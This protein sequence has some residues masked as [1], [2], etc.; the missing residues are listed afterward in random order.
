VQQVLSEIGAA[1]IPQLLVLNKMD[2]LP[3]GAAEAE[4]LGRRLLGESDE[5]AAIRAIAISGLSGEGVDRLLAAIDEAL[6]L[7]PIVTATFHLSA[8][9][10]A[11]LA[12]LH[13]LGR[14]LEVKYD[15]ESCEVRAEVP[16]SVK[17]RLEK[18][19]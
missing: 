18:K 12:M 1:E 9:D 11:T 8:G 10:G 3:G 16:E 6:P 13:E 17:R 5:K 14:V 19:P 15:G 4:S 2:C 7:D